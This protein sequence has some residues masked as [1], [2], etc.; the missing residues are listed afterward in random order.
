MAIVTKHRRRRLLRRIK[1]TMPSIPM[2]CPDR[3][4]LPSV[5]VVR[6]FSLVVSHLYSRF[7]GRTC[8]KLHSKKCIHSAQHLV[9]VFLYSQAFRLP[10]CEIAISKQI[11]NPSFPSSRGGERSDCEISKVFPFTRRGESLI[12][13]TTSEMDSPRPILASFLKSAH[14]SSPSLL[15]CRLLRLRTTCCRKEFL[16]R[17]V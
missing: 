1:T 2:R 14:L 8:C 5:K 16:E 15:R 12:P 9:N 4:Q 6:L 17:K 11:P 13:G 10:H 7:I 3:P